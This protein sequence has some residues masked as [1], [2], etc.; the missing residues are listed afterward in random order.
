MHTVRSPAAA[1]SAICVL[2]LAIAKYILPPALTEP[3]VVT[4][5]NILLLV[6]VGVILAANP[7]I[8]V[9]SVEDEEKVS[10]LVALTT[11]NTLPVGIPP[12]AILVNGI[13]YSYAYGLSPNVLVSQAALSLA[14]V[15]ALDIALAA[16]A[17]LNA[18]FFATL[19]VFA[20]ASSASNAFI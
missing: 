1:P 12:S 11:C 10:V 17:S 19:A 5:I 2:P 4:E 8:L 3:E 7:V 20:S 16:G 15:S 13:P 9:K 18:F 14:I 6:L